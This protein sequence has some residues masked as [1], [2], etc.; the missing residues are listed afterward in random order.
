MVHEHR[1]LLP[2]KTQIYNIQY[3]IYKYI[4]QIYIYTNI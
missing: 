2:L 4:I 3:T 1:A